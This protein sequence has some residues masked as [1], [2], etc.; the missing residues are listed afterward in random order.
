[1]KIDTLNHAFMQVMV[2]AGKHDLQFTYQPKGIRLSFLLSLAGLLLMIG[3]FIKYRFR[4]HQ[5]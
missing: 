2:P 4:V 1:M 5:A 3:A